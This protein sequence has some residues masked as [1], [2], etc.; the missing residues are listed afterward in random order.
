MISVLVKHNGKVGT[1]TKSSVKF[2]KHLDDNKTWPKAKEWFRDALDNI[3]EIRKYSGVESNTAQEARDEIAN[4][5]S[6]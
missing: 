1:L 5:M 3:M 2:N 6:M 4:G